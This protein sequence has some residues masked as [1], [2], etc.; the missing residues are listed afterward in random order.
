[1]AR[2]ENID[3]LKK[4][5]DLGTKL[6]KSLTAVN[7]QA[8]KRNPE[9]MASVTVGFTQNYALYVHERVNA[10]HRVG[11]A[12]F[13]ETPARQLGRELGRLVVTAVRRGA[14]LEQALLIAGLRLQGEA[15]KLTPVQTGALKGSAFTSLTRDADRAAAQAFQRSE[16]LRK[17]GRKK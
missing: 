11:Q 7:L 13:L 4:V 5:L 12:K 14:S 8:L 10:Y 9:A 3:R 15:Q 2:I 17:K 16:R 6:S 1:M